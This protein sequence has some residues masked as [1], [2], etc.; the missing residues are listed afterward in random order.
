[1]TKRNSKNRLYGFSRAEV[2]CKEY[3][4]LA[5]SYSVVSC[6]IPK[7]ALELNDLPLALPVE[8]PGRF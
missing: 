1:M 4:G 7:P 2:F 5:E 8:Q 3:V 6:F